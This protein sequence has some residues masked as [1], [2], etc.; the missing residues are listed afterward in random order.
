MGINISPRWI[1][2]MDKI[3]SRKYIKDVVKDIA[4]H[5]NIKEKIKGFEDSFI[6]FAALERL[7]YEPDICDELECYLKRRRMYEINV[8]EWYRIRKV[9]FERDNYICQYC[10]K[11]GGILEVDHSIP[12]SKGGSDS[13][14]NLVTACRKCNRQKRDK[15]KEDFVKW[16]NGIK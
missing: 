5:P 3:H 9:V 13:Y 7:Y 4:E 16:K 12:F 14:D 1:K 15:S 2:A 11:R 10:G 6:K 8:K